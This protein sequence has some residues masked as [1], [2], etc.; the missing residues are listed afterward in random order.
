L[1]AA[2]MAASAHAGWADSPEEPS[3]AIAAGKFNRDG[4]ADVVKA[5]LPDGKDSRQHVLTV[6]LGKDDGT[7]VS[8]PSHNL[9][10]RIPERWLW[11]TSMGTATLT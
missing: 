5:T 6:Q 10:A 11:E 3:V 2:I 8:V 9:M 7:L 4:I 1:V